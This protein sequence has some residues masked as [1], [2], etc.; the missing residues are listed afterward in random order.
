MFLSGRAVFWTSPTVRALG[1]RLTVSF[2][3]ARLD[4]DKSN[5]RQCLPWEKQDSEDIL[6]HEP[7]EKIKAE[8][9]ICIAV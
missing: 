4:Q 3:T 9:K 1:T 2:V 5:E 6:P 7:R 8:W